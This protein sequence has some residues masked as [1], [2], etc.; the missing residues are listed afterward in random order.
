[1]GDIKGSDLNLAAV[2]AAIHYRL[3]MRV[4]GV[5]RIIDQ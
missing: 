4:F 3:T 2:S 5:D 1:M